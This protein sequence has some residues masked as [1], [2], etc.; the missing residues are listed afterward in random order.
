M[1][2]LGRKKGGGGLGKEAGGTEKG[3]IKAGEGM[4]G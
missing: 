2:E 1:K 3:D 4:W